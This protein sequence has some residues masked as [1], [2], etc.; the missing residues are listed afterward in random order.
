M[1]AT[2]TK[3]LSLAKL[4]LYVFPCSATNKRPVIENGFLQASTD[5]A[6]ID[7]WWAEYPRAVVGVASGMSGFV[8]LDIDVKKDENGNVYKDGYDSLDKWDLDVPDTFMYTSVNGEGQHFIYRDPGNVRLGPASDYRKMPGIDR[9]GGG[10]YVVWAGDVPFSKAEF[11]EAPEWLLDEAVVRSRDEF[12]GPTNLW[13][14][15]LVPGKPNLRVRN[16]LARVNQDMDHEAMVKAQYEAVRLGAEGNTGVPE[17]LEALED[18]FL[19]RPA[20]MH[21]TPESKW[22]SDFARALSSAVE[23]FGGSIELLKTM[24]EYNISMIPAQVPASL[25]V[26][27]AGD[28][29]TFRRLMMTL[30]PLIDNDMKV[31]TILWNC[32]TTKDVSREWGLDFTLKRVV[33]ARV[34]PEP[35]KREN[36]TLEKRTQADASQ[37]MTPEEREYVEDHPTFIDEYLEAASFGRFSQP[38]YA[39]TSAWTLLSMVYG[40]RGIIPIAEGGLGLNLWFNILGYSSTGKSS[41]LRF[42]RSCLD[43][44]LSGGEGHYNLGATSSPE[45]IHKTLLERDGKVSMV[46]QDEASGFFEN[47]SKKDW[48]AS[49]ADDWADYYD[50]YVKPMT[51]IGLKEMSGKHAQT[52]F[53]IHMFATPDK[54]LGLISTDMFDT[55][56]LARFNWIWGPP[57][58]AGDEKYITQF[59]KLSDK[60]TNPKAFDLISDLIFATRWLPDDKAVMIGAETGAHERLEL[61]YAMMDKSAQS[62]DKYST[63]Q[64]AVDRLGRQTIWK[65]AALLALY[66]GEKTIRLVDALTAIYYAEDWY[67]D[68]FRVIDA[69][70]EGEFQKDCNEIEAY[71]KTRPNGVSQQRIYNTFKRIVQKST[72][73]LDERLTM[74]LTS[75]RI[76]TESRNETLY[77]F[78]N[79]G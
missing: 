20:E 39:I 10:S 27:E 65:C 69:A 29:D 34:T 25:M 24:P 21:H 31:L 41:A 73:E 23:K 67:N 19:S 15:T 51:K 26:G 8:A 2:K 54:L 30:L 75:G 50:G 64:V 72:R 52:S 5:K 32:P 28:K 9:R 59:S 1:T 53:N 40:L 74:L 56:F 70:G 58:D 55:G 71:L 44:Y 17:L 47:L 22:E 60:G 66:R 6:Q 63:V 62:H 3:A 13:Y 78:L 18:A 12:D 38:K 79:G 14:E 76:K 36:P 43:L 45:G 46:L 68:L 42:L 7:A 11:G 49:L 33:E 61:A 35:L 48:M 77:Y 4:G 16:A 37:L 57:S